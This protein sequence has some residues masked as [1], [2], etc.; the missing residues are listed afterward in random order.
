MIQEALIEHGGVEGLTADAIDEHIKAT[1]HD[2]PQHHNILFRHCLDK[3]T[4]D[5]PNSK[6][7]LDPSG[8]Y[9]IPGKANYDRLKATAVA[10]AY[11]AHLANLE[12]AERVY[13]AYL[14]PSL[15]KR[16]LPSANKK[17]NSITTSSTP[18]GT[19]QSFVDHKKSTGSKIC[20]GRRTMGSNEEGTAQSFASDPSQAKPPVDES[21]SGGDKRPVTKVKGPPL[22][23]EDLRG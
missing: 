14:V 5:T 2:L 15:W 9:T 11:R 6:L 19:T 16:Y 8:R 10:T 13:Q 22:P 3:S 4:D 20:D 18:T 1:Y 23:M 17:T 7:A 12:V 21:A